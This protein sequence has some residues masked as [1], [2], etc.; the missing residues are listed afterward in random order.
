MIEEPFAV[1]QLSP[2]T[3]AELWLYVKYGDAWLA[4]LG[5]EASLGLGVI[6]PGVRL[7]GVE[8]NADDSDF[9]SSVEPFVRMAAGDPP[10]TAIS[11]GRMRV[12]GDLSV[13]VRLGDMFGAIEPFEIVERTDILDPQ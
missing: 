10:V 1:G 13:L 5:A 6:S 9:Q 3:T 2:E 8:M 4:Q 12:T 7:Q 11:E